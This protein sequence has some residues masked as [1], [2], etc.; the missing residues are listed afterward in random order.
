VLLKAV[1]RALKRPRGVSFSQG[2]W[3]GAVEKWYNHAEGYYVQR[4]SSGIFVDVSGRRAKTSP[5]RAHV[6]KYLRSAHPGEVKSILARLETSFRTRPLSDREYADAVLNKSQRMAAISR[7]GTEFN[8]A[9][10]KWLFDDQNWVFLCKNKP[11][12]HREFFGVDAVYLARIRARL[13][14]CKS[15]VLKNLN[16]LKMYQN[17]YGV[18]ILAGDKA[19]MAL[20]WASQQAVLMDKKKWQAILPLTREDTLL[21]TTLMPVTQLW[22]KP[23]NKIPRM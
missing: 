2:E 3:P 11:G 13:A 1:Q 23:V 22:E 21:T 15:D 14:G 8:A 19:A 17:K 20:L 18:G 12:V 4:G 7:S 10:A 9:L 6:S 16:D 5:L